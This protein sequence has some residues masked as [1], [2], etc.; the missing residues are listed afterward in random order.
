MED[1][2][3]S[4]VKKSIIDAEAAVGFFLLLLLFAIFAYKNIFWKIFITAVAKFIAGATERKQPTGNFIDRRRENKSERVNKYI[5]QT[6]SR[7]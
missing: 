7:Q 6:H 4:F 1:I 5:Q 2:S 3:N